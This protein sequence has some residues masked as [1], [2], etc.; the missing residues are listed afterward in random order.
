M[1]LWGGGENAPYGVSGGCLRGRRLFG[2]PGEPGA[3]QAGTQADNGMLHGQGGADEI[4]GLHGLYPG[5]AANRHGGEQNV[6]GP[7]SLAEN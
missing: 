1:L 2:E 3:G 4:Q 6:F 7:V 5:T